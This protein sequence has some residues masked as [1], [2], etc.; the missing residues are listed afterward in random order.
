VQD[1]YNTLKVAKT[2]SQE[3]IKKSYKK[4]SKVYHPDKNPN[5]S[6]AEDKFKAIAEAYDTLGDPK[7]RKKYDA[8]MSFSFDFNRWESAFGKS[9]TTSFTKPAKKEPPKG[10][11]LKITI[12]LTLEEISSGLDK[13]V[14]VNK[15]NVCKICDGMGAKSYKPCRLCHG[16]GMIRKIRNVNIIS[17]EVTI[18]TCTTCQG[19]GMEIDEACI[20]CNGLG[21]VKEDVKI[22]IEI[23]PLMTNNQFM[24]I[25]GKGDAGMRGGRCGNIQV[26]IK[27][28]PHKIFKRE[29]NNLMFTSDVSI[30]D[31]VLGTTVTVPTLDGKVEMKIPAGSQPDTIFK[32]SGKG[33]ANKG[34]LLVGTNLI[35]P[36][37]LTDDEKKLFEELRKL[38]KEF[39]F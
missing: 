21:R 3:E 31:L 14:K 9:N 38:E 20:P 12:S 30:T 8:K 23:P 5:D 26:Y 19:T 17:R 18:V 16:E 37:K 36:E 35:I 27:E 24:I 33:L 13:F 4:L 39:I 15:Y 25:N 11:D 7:K 34:N 32:I 2:A 28:L 6:V 1:F 29:G 22:K 10:D